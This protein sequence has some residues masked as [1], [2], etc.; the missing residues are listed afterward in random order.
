MPKRLLTSLGAMT[1]EK[2]GRKT[3]REAAKEISIGPATLMR[4][5]NGRIP[6]VATFGKICQWLEVNP[7]TFFELGGFS[8]TDRPRT[9]VLQPIQISA[10]LKVDQ[11]PRQE[12]IDALSKMIL[13]AMAKQGKPESTPIDDDV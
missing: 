7:G 3:L 9:N 2:R 13:V 5:E 10:H 11:T 8:L 4:V 6:D 1:R 12:T